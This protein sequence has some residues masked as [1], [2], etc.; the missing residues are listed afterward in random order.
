[1]QPI[2]PSIPGRPFG[3]PRAFLATLDIF[4]QVPQ[5]ILPEI[6]RKMVERRFAKGD[7]IFLEGD[8]AQNV[9]F[10]KEGHAKALVHTATGR[11]LALCMMGPHSLFGTCCCFGGGEYP[12][13][14]VAETDLTVVSFPMKD[15]QDLMGRFPEMAKA[16]VMELS[17]RLR[18][19]KDM[20][21]FDQESV[22][23]RILH[24]LADLVSEFGNTIPLTRREIAEMTGTTVETCIRTF[25]ALE[26]EGLVAGARGKITVRDPQALARRLEKA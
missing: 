20:H 6:E 24:V 10:V 23:K 11:D 21:T 19:S 1:M 15:F 5:G 17:K 3:T 7:S 26:K 13:H 4:K 22:E 25:S 12:C 9:W 16:V 18:H 2:K 14:A 8:P